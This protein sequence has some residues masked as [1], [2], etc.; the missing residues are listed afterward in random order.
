MYVLPFI[1]KKSQQL[2]TRLLYSIENNLKFCQSSHHTNWV[3]CSVIN[4]PLRKK[5]ALTLFTVTRAVTARLLI[6]VKHTATFLLELQTIWVYCNR[7]K[8][9]L[10]ISSV[11]QSTVSDHLVECNCLIGFDHFDILATDARFIN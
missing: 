3:R 7:K 1:R 5:S 2:R 4:V 9:V 11:K 8:N 10:T 6:M